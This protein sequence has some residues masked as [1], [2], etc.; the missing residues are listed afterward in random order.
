MS[1]EKHGVVAVEMAEAR[2]EEEC[3]GRGVDGGECLDIEEQPQRAPAGR[4][5]RRDERPAAPL[6][7]P[8]GSNR[9]EGRAQ[10]AHV[11]GELTQEWRRRVCRFTH[12]LTLEL[13]GE[14]GPRTVDCT[15]ESVAD[16]RAGEPT[17]AAK[18]DAIGVALTCHALG[19]A[20]EL[21]VLDEMTEIGA[22]AHVMCPAG[23]PR[24]LAEA[25]GGLTKHG[26]R[27]TSAA[28]M[29]RCSPSG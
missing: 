17:R 8:Q 9:G 27:A 3:A 1:R 10:Q 4:A 12:E 2:A 29:W 25:C 26:E 15:D 18:V 11:R 21:S 20:I 6:C 13:C 22:V 5:E 23:C 19:I 24:M 7:L 28:Q 16:G 14:L